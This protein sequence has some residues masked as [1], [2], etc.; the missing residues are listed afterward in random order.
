[1]TDTT[2]VVSIRR[3]GRQQQQQLVR[4]GSE[5]AGLSARQKE[6][7]GRLS[8]LC[9]RQDGLG[10][11]QAGL[12]ASLQELGGR[13]RRGNEDVE[14]LFGR[15]ER[16]EAAKV[17]DRFSGWDAVISKRKKDLNSL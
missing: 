1:M 12:Q 6:L 4:L 16:L 2:R 5:L 13:V 11:Q 9:C 8:R 7:G 17:G 14:L 10:L 3:S 15:I